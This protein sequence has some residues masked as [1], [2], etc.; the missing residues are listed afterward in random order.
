[1][2]EE[3]LSVRLS[4]SFVCLLLNIDL[5]FAAEEIILQLCIPPLL[6][7]LCLE[8]EGGFVW[9]HSRLASEESI[10]ITLTRKPEGLK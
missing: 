6:A 5:V 10:K 9:I 4:W 1:M 2:W 7:L 3:E 8:H